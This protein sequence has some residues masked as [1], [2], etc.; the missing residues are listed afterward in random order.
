L[1][2]PHAACGGKGGNKPDDLQ[3]WRTGLEQAGLENNRC[4]DVLYQFDSAAQ[5]LASEYGLSR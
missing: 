4:Q 2:T 1:L 3:Q 5:I